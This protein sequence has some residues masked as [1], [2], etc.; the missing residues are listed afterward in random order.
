VCNRS[1]HCEGINSCQPHKLDNILLLA[2]PTRSAHRKEGATGSVRDKQIYCKSDNDQLEKH[3][4]APQKFATSADLS[5]KR[6][7]FRDQQ[8]DDSAPAR[9]IYA[10][11]TLYRAANDD[12]GSA[13]DCASAADPPAAASETTF[14]LY[15]IYTK[16]QICDKTLSVA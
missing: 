9:S 6:A 13:R 16:V 7:Y 3:L 15:M 12:S 11:G 2:A 1:A 8:Q 4:A 5:V 14:K 10:D